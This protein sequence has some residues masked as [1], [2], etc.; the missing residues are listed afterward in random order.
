MEQERSQNKSEGLGFSRGGGE[1]GEVKKRGKL[2]VRKVQPK[3]STRAR[4]K[5]G[6]YSASSPEKVQLD[7]KIISSDSKGE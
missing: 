6:N 4:D 3:K 7:I 2:Y 1:V 5:G